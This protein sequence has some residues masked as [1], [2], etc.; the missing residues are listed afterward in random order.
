MY[1]LKDKVVLVTGGGKRIGAGICRYLHACGA[2]IIVHCHQSVAQMQ[3][4]VAELNTL[5]AGSA[6]GVSFDLLDFE[7]YPV[8]GGQVM[9]C[10]GRL[11]I[12]INNASSFYPTT[13]PTL[14]FEKWD[15]LLGTNAKVPFFLGNLFADE[16]SRCQGSIVGMVDIHADRPLPNH[17]VYSIAKAAHLQVIKTLALELAPHVRVNGV[18]P[19]SNIWPDNEV[20][21][22]KEVRAEFESR[23]PLGRIGRPEDI[24]S[25]VAFLLAHPYISGEIIKCDG[26]RDIVF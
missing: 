24:A 21:F 23:I 10:F 5:R 4:L 18:A 6:C 17:A 19:G 8:F 26:G 1:D 22:D 11:D 14:D 7:A 2:V 12:L 25:T 16:L 20:S 13:H 3:A 15:E 9:A